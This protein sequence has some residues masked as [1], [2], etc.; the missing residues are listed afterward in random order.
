MSE[1]LSWSFK[2]DDLMSGPASKIDAA[3][4]GFDEKL[5]ASDAG[6][7]AL[8]ERL[9]AST[10]A[11]ERL[12]A[13][14]RKADPARTLA[15]QVRSVEA[16]G[17]FG[18]HG[19]FG[20]LLTGGL[21]G[22]VPQIF[23]ATELASRVVHLG[24]SFAGAAV[25]AAKFAIE[26]TAA[27]QQTLAAMEVMTGSRDT[28]ERYYR[29]IQK[30]TDLTPFTQQDTQQA[31][32]SLVGLGLKLPE[33]TAAMAAM[34]DASAAGGTGAIGIQRMGNALQ[35]MMAT[36]SMNL[37]HVRE[38]IYGS[39]GLVSMQ[40]FLDEV[41]KAHGISAHEAE[42]QLSTGAISALEGLHYLEGD[43]AKN[44]DR[45][46]GLGFMAQVLGVGQMQGQLTILQ[47]R[48]ERLFNSVDSGPIKD[49][50]GNLNDLLDD[51]RK[52]GKRLKAVIDDL[53]G[54]TFKAFFAEYT[55]ANGAKAMKADFESLLDSLQKIAKAL[56]VIAKVGGYAFSITK[57]AALGANETT[58]TSTRF[59][60]AGLAAAA[61]AIP[62]VGPALSVWLAEHATSNRLGSVPL[63]NPPAPASTGPAV[64]AEV[65]VT[66]PA[67][68]SKEHSDAMVRTVHEATTSALTSAMEQAAHRR[69][70]L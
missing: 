70:A 50:L 52:S 32:Q 21:G 1:G 31:F 27:K 16:E 46:K 55:G 14:V 6:L 26:Q 33:V 41:G 68:A 44:I 4:A 17:D 43:I 49:T 37:R 8:D 53:F 62:L 36:G 5:R 63:S 69:G 20:K 64:H 28:A 40:R 30:F 24:E 54:R 66:V 45:G 13:A 42:Q 60:V 19:I 3:L 67:D 47:N 48:F 38:F 39:G 11:M 2:L 10:A 57:T 7:R 65:H 56:E 58:S 9:G 12:D 51:N 29:F 59:G 23:F 34:A 15:Q 22:A 35:E 61:G 25:G 18:R